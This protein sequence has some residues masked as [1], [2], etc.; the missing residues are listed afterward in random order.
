MHDVISM[1][2][3]QGHIP[4]IT[5]CEYAIRDI[6]LLSA[7]YPIFRVSH[8][9]LWDFETTVNTQDRQSE[10]RA[11]P[12]R[13][14]KTAHQVPIAFG[15][16]TIIRGLG[17]KDLVILYR[18]LIDAWGQ[19]RKGEIS[20]SGDRRKRKILSRSWLYEMLHRHIIAFFQLGDGGS[21]ILAGSSF[22][23]F[24]F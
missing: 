9:S 14:Y 21:I 20:N 16:I 18:D 17:L 4:I 13:V 22:F 6:C 8:K 11:Y 12:T 10:K 23:S 19:D 24:N 2:T 1:Q 15:Q 7:H 5:M 3:G